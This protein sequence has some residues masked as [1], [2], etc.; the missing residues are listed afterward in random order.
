MFYDVVVLH[1]C[2]TAQMNLYCDTT[3]TIPLTMTGYVRREVRNEF[4]TDKKYR[5]DF[6][7]SRLDEHQYKLCCNAFSGGLT[8]GNRFYANET[9]HGNIRH[10]D[11]IS[12]YP[13]QQRCYTF[14]RGKFFEY[15]NILK[16][17]KPIELNTVLN[18]SSQFCYLITI[19]VTELQVKEGITLPT[20]QTY[21]FYQ[22]RIEL[23]Q[24]TIEDNGRLLYFKGN[25][26]ITLC[27]SDFEILC[28]QYNMRFKIVE[29]LT[30]VRGKCPKYMINSVD[31]F[32]YNKTMFKNQYELTKNRDDYLML[33]LSKNN[34]NG[35]YGM[36]A[37]KLVRDEWQEKNGEW[38]KKE[39]NNDCIKSA[40]D[41]Y[42]NGFNNF[43]SYQLGV[44]TTANARW[45]LIE[46]VELIGYD[47]FI[48]A[49]TDSIFYFSDSD[50]E[51]KINAKNAELRE[52]AERDK[53][54]IE[55][56]G[57]RQYYN[58]FKLEKENITDFRFLH[59][60][61]YAYITDNTEL[62]C[63]IAGVS[64]VGADGTTREAELQTI[65]N[66]KHNFVFTKCGGT[67]TKYFYNAPT[68]EYIDGHKTEFSAG[69]VIT[70][71]I[72][73]LNGVIASQDYNF[74]WSV[75]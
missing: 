56:D 36:S 50:T 60:K 66:L 25:S 63:T 74:E 61:C 34:L 12:H 9:L 46:F 65:D 31:R 16:N 28:R 38:I 59:S 42:Y 4:K 71:N 43:N 48:Y 67:K 19:N 22:G 21:K 18:L 6:L 32:F 47:K 3:K 17:K 7:N 57:Q 49:D 62:H 44:W 55:Y 51:N 54:Y 39:Q 52:K 15:Y 14:P 11:F 29:I 37:T 73:T 64:A 23:P 41:K 27:D 13:T 75:D 30:A 26:I 58:E 35:I 8:H 2:I 1:E 68:T 20:A 53:C 24:K 69:A 70:N 72:K 45:E 10:R 40:L 5:R 33:M